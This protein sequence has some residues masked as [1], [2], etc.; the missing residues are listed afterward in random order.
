MLA[1]VS[2]TA[3]IVL[4]AILVTQL[5]RFLKWKRH[6]GGFIKKVEGITGKIECTTTAFIYSNPDETCVIRWEEIMQVRIFKSYLLLNTSTDKFMFIATTMEP[7]E[8]RNL[9]EVLES[10]VTRGSNSAHFNHE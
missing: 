8:Y 9:C 5:I 6:V 2:L 4:L 10:T 3:F 1:S 7:D